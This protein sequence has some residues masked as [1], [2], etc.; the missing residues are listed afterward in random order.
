MIT[1][2]DFA[3]IDDFNTL[4]DSVL[5]TAVLF[6]NCDGY[7]QSKILTEECAELIV[8]LSHFERNRKGSFSEIL[9]EL[10]HV[11]ISC[12]AFIICANIPLDRIIAEVNKKYN[13]YHFLKSEVK[14][15]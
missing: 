5:K 15:P 1:R 12:F 3:P 6:E 4:F 7:S 8:A 9:E 13:K 11:L 10:S 14:K 2:K